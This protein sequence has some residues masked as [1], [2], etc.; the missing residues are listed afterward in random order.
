MWDSTPRPA[1]EHSSL[2]LNMKKSTYAQNI[3][4]FFVGIPKG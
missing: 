2:E 3:G 4:G 1:K